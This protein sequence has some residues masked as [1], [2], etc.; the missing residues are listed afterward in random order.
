MLLLSK[1][2]KGALLCLLFLAPFAMAQAPQITYPSEANLEGTIGQRQSWQ[3]ESDQWDSGNEWSV[4]GTL[5]DGLWLDYYYGGYCQIF[6]EPTT[7]G[8]FSFT[9]RIENSNGSST[10]TFTMEIKP[11]PPPEIAY[12]EESSLEVALGQYVD[13]E[14]QSS[15]TN[16]DE[17]WSVVGAL[18]DGLE[19]ADW[20]QREGGYYCYIS[21][22]PTSAGTFPF[23]LRIEN[24][25]GSS[26]RTFTLNV[27]MPSSPEIETA[28]LPGGTMGEYYREYLEAS[29]FAEW[30][31]ESG[32]LPDGLW[33]S[34]YN[35]GYGYIGG[36]PTKKGTYTFTV[37]A[38]NVSGSS[39]KQF[40]ITIDA[41]QQKPQI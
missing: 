16:W 20:C 30:R 33:L 22:Q 15:Q 10:R 32:A 40:S 23:T 26:T 3:F 34:S 1:K 5:P 29:D 6:G 37:K 4:V 12:P 39:T 21:G 36:M 38:E 17:E 18:P 13:W 7:T 19:L 28:S 41:E 9:L 2:I 31:V 14:F 35:N 27:R 24:S 8:T 25:K 11:P